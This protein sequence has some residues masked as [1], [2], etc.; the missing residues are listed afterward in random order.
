MIEFGHLCVIAVGLAS[1]W[2]G[3][4]ERV[5]KKRFDQELESLEKLPPSGQR[6]FFIRHLRRDMGAEL[7]CNRLAK[8]G[9]LSMP[10]FAA[11][12]AFFPEGTR[13]PAGASA[14]IIA[15]AV[16]S[17]LG[18]GLSLASIFGLSYGERFM[19]FQQPNHH[20]IAPD[21][22][23]ILLKAKQQKEAF[24]EREE[25]SRAAKLPV[26]SKR[27]DGSSRRL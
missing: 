4:R 22:M 24:E 27:L 17:T 5:A 3:F 23:N 11:L 19:K 15:S 9:G 12:C 10:V 8:L 14:G 13:G 20:M 25:L 2:G 21:I 18:G 16:L 7:I 6:D 1:A 26:A